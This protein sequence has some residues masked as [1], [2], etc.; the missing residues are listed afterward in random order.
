MRGGL[1]PMKYMLMFCSEADDENRFENRNEESRATMYAQVGEW[2]QK[3]NSKFVAGEQLQ[4]PETATTVRFKRGEKPVV[5]D[6]PF[7]EG[8]EIIGG[9]WVI[10]VQD[11]DEALTMA[12]EWPASSIVEVRP[13]LERS[14]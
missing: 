6:G 12:K 13:I 7:I 1:I 4:S 14:G 11:L 3:Y 10:D 9:F 5:T 2:A 8:K